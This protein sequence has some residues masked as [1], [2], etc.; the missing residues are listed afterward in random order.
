MSVLLI[1]CYLTKH[2]PQIVAQNNKHLLSH[3][4]SQSGIQTQLTWM[5]CLGVS[6]EVAVRIPVWAAITRRLGW[7]TGPASKMASAQGAGHGQEA[8]GHLHVDLSTSFL[9]A[10]MTWLLASPRV[11]NPREQ[12]RSHMSVT[13]QP[14][15]SHSAISTV[16][17]QLQ[18]SASSGV[19]QTTQEC[20]YQKVRIIGE[21]GTINMT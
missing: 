2:S 10:L 7:T 1:F 8:L 19:G 5:V 14:Q 12:G 18:R 4:F 9:R 11:I 6:H 3:S 17:Y 21:G 16:S 15:K 13:T 20:D